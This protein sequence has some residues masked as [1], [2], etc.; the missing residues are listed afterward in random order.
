MK[1]RFHDIFS[2]SLIIHEE[3]TKEITNMKEV[4][5]CDSNYQ[6]S[7]W[8]FAL[9]FST[10]INALRNHIKLYKECFIRYPNTSKLVEKNSAAPR[11]FNPL[12][13]VWISDETLFVVFDIL[14]KRL[15]S[16]A[17]VVWHRWGSWNTFKFWYQK[18]CYGSNFQR[19]EKTKLT[20]RFDE[21]KANTRNV[22]FVI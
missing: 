3:K 18:C 15:D 20:F 17:N 5:I 1:A 4:W 16:K 21:A 8:T 2:K 13:T 22:I 19:E 10:I 12:L 14:H 11:F 7:Q 9:N 6:K